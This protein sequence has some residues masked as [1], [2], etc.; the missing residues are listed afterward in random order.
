[1][2]FAELILPARSDHSLAEIYILFVKNSILLSILVI[3]E[4][5]IDKVL[6]LMLTAMPSQI[7][8]W[9]GI[10]TDFFTFGTKAKFIKVALTKLEQERA[11]WYVYAIPKPSSRKQA[12]FTAYKC[13]CFTKGRTTFVKRMVQRISQRVRQWIRN[14]LWPLWYPK[15]SRDMFDGNRKCQYDDNHFL[16]QTW[17]GNPYL[18]VNSFWITSNRQILFILSL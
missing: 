18:L 11:S 5:V 14:I 6:L 13:Q 1:M 17:R 12:I 16:N 15:K 10:Q 7:T 8:R 4:D 2:N 3:R 9:Q